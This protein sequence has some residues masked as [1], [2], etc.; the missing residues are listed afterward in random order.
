M[1]ALV[2]AM[3]VAL[4]SAS[5][6]ALGPCSATGTNYL[7]IGDTCTIE[8]AAGELLTHASASDKVV[9]SLSDNGDPAAGTYGDPAADP[10]E[11]PSVFTVGAAGTTATVTAK[12]IGSITIT[13]T[14]EAAGATSEA[15]A[16]FKIEVVA[17]GSLEVIFDDTDA[18]V[19]A[20]TEVQVGIRVRAGT[21]GGADDATNTVAVTLK[22]PTT[23]VYFL[24]LGTSG[25]VGGT[26]EEADSTSQIAS[27]SVVAS[28]E[29]E[30]VFATR[31][32]QTAGAPAGEYI[33][34]A[35]L[36]ADIGN[37]KKGDYTAKLTIGDPGTGLASANLA[38]DTGQKTS[39]SVNTAVG[40]VATAKNSL[41]A[42][43]NDGDVASILVNATGGTIIFASCGVDDSTTPDDEAP[44]REKT[45]FAQLVEETTGDN[46]GF[47][48]TD[49]DGTV[50]AADD[51]PANDPDDTGV[52]SVVKFT[53]SKATAG[54]VDVHVTMI[55]GA[56]G[57]ASSETITL[58]FAGAADAI[59]VGP[60]SNNLAQKAGKITFE[61]TA[62]DKGGNPA[63]VNA[64]AITTVLKDSE[65][66]TP[67]NLEAEDAQKFTDSNANGEKDA[68][69][70]DVTTAVIVTVESDPNNNAGAG[71]YT[72]EV[73]LNNDAS[74][75]QV[76]S[77]TVVGGAA[78][79]GVS[80]DSTM[81]AVGDIITLTATVTDADGN[82]VTNPAPT[83]TNVDFS[84]AGALKLA[85]FGADDNGVVKKATTDGVA[86]AKFVVTNGSGTA[87]ILVNS[88]SATGTTSVST[89]AAEA[90]A[91]EE[92]S[93]A[94]LSNLSGFATW[95]CGVDSSASEIF[96]LVSGRGAT[97][98]HLW[99]GSAWVRYSVVDGTMVPGSSDFMVTEN[100]ILYISN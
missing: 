98:I 14:N 8:A 44:A 52:G 42:N 66:N 61:V 7:K 91:D 86:E 25:V 6:A 94:C 84:T 67:Q 48:D 49:C 56:A 85:G 32:L 62:T 21:G 89:E 35:T 27:A 73:L 99:N 70:K 81:V 100:D 90:M 65:G 75:K 28:A 4:Q 82:A 36:A 57:T 24:D 2:A 95:T 12:A 53:V 34:T 50:T 1:I 43:A 78:N 37:L 41:G 17:S 55:G 26:G 15:D 20:G 23:G 71:H 79:V 29:S 10:A 76:G 16:T 80:S 60:A 45:N 39:N 93:V 59:A 11:D 38:L 87:V 33:I 40:L 83:E 68:D 31:K 69:E 9:A 63:E 5:A 18:T 96:G 46:R 3:F 22:A 88:G 19:K 51:D 72:V 47:A 58:T 97:A 30:Q 74:T 13:D 54:T 77:F 92:A 64:N